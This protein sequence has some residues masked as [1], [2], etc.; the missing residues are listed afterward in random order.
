MWQGIR[1]GKLEREREGERRGDVSINKSTCANCATFRG[2]RFDTL[3]FVRGCS[4]PGKGGIGCEGSSK[5]LHNLN[6]ISMLESNFYAKPKTNNPN[7]VA[8]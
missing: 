4:Q 7:V 2:F 8:V 6:E 1:E 5:C 3:Q